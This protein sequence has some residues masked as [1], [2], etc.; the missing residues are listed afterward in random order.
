M[1]NE[2]AV[3]AL[4]AYFVPQVN[5]AFA[6]QTFYQ[7]KHKAEQSVQQFFTCLRQSAKDC[8]SG[9]DKDNQIR[10]AVLSRCNSEYVRRKLLEE[11]TDLMLARTLEIAAQCE[12]VKLQM[13]ALHVSSDSE[14]KETVS[15]VSKKGA[16]DHKKTYAIQ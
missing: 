9:A 16:R 13:A 1:D 10:D 8:D 14:I 5:A 4:N 6:R 15:L 7:L 2:Q 3:T 12:R 11:G